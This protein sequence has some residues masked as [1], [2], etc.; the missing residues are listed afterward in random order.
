MILKD[1]LRC[2]L[3]SCKQVDESKWPTVKL[4][5]VGSQLKDNRYQLNPDHSHF[6]IVH[7]HSREKTGYDK[8]LISLLRFLS[9]TEVRHRKPADLKLSLNRNKKSQ[10]FSVL[11]GEVPVVGILIGGGLES[12]KL[13]FEFIKNTFPVVILQ[14]TS[15]LADI[16]SFAYNEIHDRLDDE[17]EWGKLDDDFVESFLKPEIT[18]KINRLLP[19]SAKTSEGN[20]LLTRIIDILK[21]AWSEPNSY[22]TVVNTDSTDYPLDNISI[23]LLRAL[24]KSRTRF[25]SATSHHKKH[26]EDTVFRELMLAMDWNCIEV[27][28]ND[29][30][31]Q[32]P[33][34]LARLPRETFI[35]TLFFPGRESFIDMYLQHG[36]RT[37]SFLSPLRLRKLFLL[38]YEEEF[39]RSVCWEGILGHSPLNKLGKN[40]IEDDLN[41]L[42][43]ICT[44]LTNFINPD[45]LFYNLLT[46]YI[47]NA[48]SAER[49]SITLLAIWAGFSNRILL[50]KT[51]W[52]HCDTPIQLG[53]IMSKILQ[54]MAPYITDTN[55]QEDVQREADNFGK[56]AVGVFDEC[57]KLYPTRVLDLLSEKSPDWNQMSAVSLA[58]NADLKLFISHPACQRWLT[59]EFCG[60]IRV[61]EASWGILTIPRSIKLLCSAYFVWP[62]YFWIQFNIDD[63]IGLET[64]SKSFDDVE[65]E[66]KQIAAQLMKNKSPKNFTI[67]NRRSNW[68]SQFRA[69]E[70]FIFQR[71]P[72]WTMIYWVWTAPIT[73]FYQ[74][75]IFFCF[76]L[77][78]LCWVILQ[79]PCRASPYDR[80]IVL[81]SLV[82]A[83]ELY[84]RTMSA[85][86]TSDNYERKQLS[87]LRCFFFTIVL[88]VYA[89][90]VFHWKIP[91]I[92]L[93]PYHV[94]VLL[95][96]AIVYFFYRL[97]AIFLKISPTLGPSIYRIQLM[98]S[99]F[100]RN[101]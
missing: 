21:F 101:I 47:Q 81:W 31:P 11:P 97:L 48:A 79:P 27:A 56:M 41:F 75:Q 28:K 90:N 7:D 54:H 88:I 10:S 73:K 84:R 83:I 78:L 20:E 24:L 65:D 86:I 72:I 67:K 66:E 23:F 33:L 59:D 76:Y 52:K 17:T 25:R 60:H 3:F 12:S 74:H 22:I 42:I 29:V 18:A 63:K 93:S 89:N 37:H 77:G 46:M 53:I 13:V 8:F 55:I 19:E 49:K 69:R 57:Y 51:F 100:V 94:K 82:Y 99:D 16:M 96:F 71:V 5:D 58:A 32:D 9:T 61:R 39:F 50:A 64:R 92:I 68:F 70:Y 43:Q 91:Y 26:E 45:H 98:V 15:G 1:L 34:F 95:A 87:P 80:V 40:F 44:G 4:G 62:M 85:L 6:L 30:V 35:R 36:F 14:G 2:T 38:S